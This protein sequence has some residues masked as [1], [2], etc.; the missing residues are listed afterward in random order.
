MDKLVLPPISWVLAWLTPHFEMTTGYSL[1]L[2]AAVPGPR[3]LGSFSN[4]SSL[5]AQTSDYKPKADEDDSHHGGK[6]GTASP[7]SRLVGVRRGGNG[8]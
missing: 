8:L 4:G 2:T 6:G 1:V 3:R 5:V 7:R